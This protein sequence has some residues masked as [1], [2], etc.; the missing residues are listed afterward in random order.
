[1]N[2]KR[3]IVERHIKTHSEHFNEDCAAVS[4]LETFLK[5]DE[6]INDNFSCDDKCPNTDGTFEFVPDPVISRRLEQNFFVQ[7]KN[8]HSCNETNEVFKYSLK[9]LAFPAFIYCRETFDPGL[10]FVVLNSDERDNERV[11]W[12]YMSPDLLDSIDFATISFSPDE[13]SFSTV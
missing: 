8:T 3:K 10:L 1:M 5:S 13:E 9:S 2:H 7:I 4:V 11:F 6:K 12:K